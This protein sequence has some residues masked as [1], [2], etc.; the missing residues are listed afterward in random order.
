MKK[1]VMNILLIVIF[2][3]LQTT[4][5]SRLSIVGVVPSLMVVLIA[6]TGFM[7][8]DK[9]AL[10]MGFVCGLL[11]DL[12]TFRILGMQALILCLIGFVTG[13]FHNTFYPED[14]KL[15]LLVIT[16]SDLAYSLM[17]YFFAYLFRA[18]F[19]FGYYFLNICLPE[20]VYTLFVALL[21]Y[22]GFLLLYRF[23]IKGRVKE[24]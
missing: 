12:F 8:G 7:Q 13:Q 21:I 18:R 19:H 17:M 14:F 9:P 15:P 3:V 16:G 23:V 2:F 22:P 20:L 5:F 1:L 10:I 6:V 11:L 4:V 24:A